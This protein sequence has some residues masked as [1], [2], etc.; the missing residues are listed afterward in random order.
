MLYHNN[1][2]CYDATFLFAVNSLRKYG[3]LYSELNDPELVVMLFQ[4][5][6]I[7]SHA[8]LTGLAVN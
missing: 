4:P 1:V 7:V 5:K 6:Q 2:I 8:S 3:K